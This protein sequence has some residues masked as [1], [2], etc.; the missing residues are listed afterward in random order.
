MIVAEVR[1]A[2]ARQI[3]L[4]GGGARNPA[5]VE[6]IGIA[7]RREAMP[8]VPGAA[9]LSDDLG[10]PCEAREAM[11]FAVLGALAQDGVPITL[12]QVTG[13]KSPGHAGAWAYP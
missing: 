7:A 4:A 3:V 8:G 13:A 11:A 5:L 1:R 10:I 6:S 2:G 12:P 9:V